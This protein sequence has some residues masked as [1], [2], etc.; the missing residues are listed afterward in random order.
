MEPLGEF[1]IYE[2]VVNYLLVTNDNYYSLSE[3][4][5]LI[6]FPKISNTIADLK[7]NNKL[8][9]PSSLMGYNNSIHENFKVIKVE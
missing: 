4:N 9:S 2:N 7:N 5:Q 1:Q 8:I 3:D 6:A